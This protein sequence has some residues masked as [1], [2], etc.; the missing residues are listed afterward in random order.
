M[1]T[2]QEIITAPAGVRYM[3]DIASLNGD[4]PHNAII[5]KT[6]TGCG[7]TH[8]A[9][10]NAENYVVAV[11]FISLIKNKIAQH[12]DVLGFHYGVTNKDVWE[13][14]AKGGK[15]I[16]VTYDSVFRLAKYLDPKEWRLLVDESHMLL[17][18]AASLKPEVI[19]RLL[20]RHGEFKSAA[21]VSATP[22]RYE[23]LPDQLKALRQVKIEWTDT[24][25]VKINHVR[26]ERSE[27]RSRILRVAIDSFGR[28]D[29]PYFFF[30]SLPGIV[31]VI[32]DLRKL[33]PLGPED[34][35]IICADTAEN[36]KYLRNSL[37]HGC[38]PEGALDENGQSRNKKIN[39]VTSFGFFGADF[40]DPHAST[41][42]IS[43]LKGKGTHYD[44]STAIPQIIGRF[45][46][47][48]NP[49]LNLI[50]TTKDERLE[51]TR[52]EFEREILREISMAKQQ[53]A[54]AAKNERQHEMLVDRQ[55]TDPYFWIND[56]E[57][58]LVN[59]L[60]H[61]AEM[62]LYDAFHRDYLTINNR[63][64]SSGVVKKLIECFDG[65]VDTLEIEGL[66]ATEES[67][68]KRRPNWAKVCKEYCEAREIMDDTKATDQ[69]KTVATDTILITEGDERFK[70]LVAAYELLGP[71]RLKALK[72][73]KGD[74]ENAYLIASALTSDPRV[75]RSQLRLKTGRHY[76]YD[77]IRERL[78]TLYNHLGIEKKLFVSD[79]KKWYRA[80][81]TTR[82]GVNVLVIEGVR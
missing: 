22:G 49:V 10:T 50:W 6:V 15:K 30:N 51:Q 9:L 58:V 33:R 54:W 28:T 3:S 80:R 78:T 70:L 13:Y 1:T 8:L 46:Q 12:P 5:D 27:V 79:I 62:E 32:K 21:F 72:Y 19:N 63:N 36:R 67:Q 16:M 20:T 38:I 48:D 47:Q 37:G 65:A 68:L 64:S 29:H 26:I 45:R 69:E 75:I 74:I 25:P 23:Y 77:E 52:E 18:F 43:D 17:L 44:I 81:R 41:W 31:R 55:K 61:N 35:K 53:V 82:Q 73:R 24:T 7:A 2:I 66:T 4:L 34:I 14:L 59:E 76:S 60:I 40:L 71:G 42:V 56:A 39:F 57:E 11:P